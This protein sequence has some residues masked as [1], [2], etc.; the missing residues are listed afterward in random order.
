M[1][2]WLRDALALLTPPRGGV[3]L[4]LP[5]ELDWRVLAL[6]AGVCVVS[7]LLFGLMPAML[8]SNIDLASALRSQSGGVVG[9]RR[10]AW[11]RSTLVLVQMSLSFVLLVGAD[12]LIQSLRAVRHA[13]P[14]FSTE[15]VLTTGVDLFTAGYDAQRAK[16]FQDELIDRL[17]ALGGVESAALSRMT[18]FSYRS[19]STA[20]IAVDGYDAPPNEQ[21]T[22]DFN[23]IGPQF[24]ATM[25]IPLVSGREFTRA[26]T[27]TAPPVA[28]VDETMAAQFWRGVD[29]IGRRVQVKGRWMQVVG[30]AR[31]ARYWNLLETPK[32]FFYVALRQHFSA[33]TAL[34]IRT[35][36]GPAAFA[37][38]LVREIHALDPNVAP[39]ELIT[40][41]EQ[42]ERTTAA[43]RISVTI[44]AVVGGLAVVLAAI[45]LYGVMASTVSQSSRELALR[46]ALGAGASD[47]LRLVLSKG[48]A[49]T[50]GGL[51][52]GLVVA[53][54]VTRL[55]GY[56]LYK[57]SP[58]DPVAFGS[59]FVVIIVASLI[60][61]VVPAWR[62][63]R[64]DPLHALR[65]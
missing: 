51:V 3:L 64:T 56:L 61:C 23:E 8:T 48:L 27:E 11:V 9:A 59:A 36:Q 29:P 52:L 45:G 10:R 50:A 35:T 16:N 63:T 5:G 54:Q 46:M 60:A 37:P 25:G 19:Y 20:P 62:A 44:L 53:L 43:Q 30:V 57:V 33:T 41:R 34:H 18:P 14:G 31:N 6:S 49:L 26:D 65:G 58:R 17:Q 21:A 1:A 13:S 4:R 12:L 22:A 38:S 40:M 42:V 15:G 32:P 28:V 7:T 47:L 24:L 2:N 39:S 55:L